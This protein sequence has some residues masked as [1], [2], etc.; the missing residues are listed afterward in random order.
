MLEADALAQREARLRA[1]S[2][3]KADDAVVSSLRVFEWNVNAAS[4]ARRHR[5]NKVLASLETDLVVLTEVPRW[6]A[7]DYLAALASAGL[8][9]GVSS[10]TEVDD[11]PSGDGRR[12]Y[13]VVVASRWP[14]SEARSVV[15]APWPERTLAATLSHPDAAVEVIAVYAPLG[16]HGN[17]KS[18]TFEAIGERLGVATGPVIVTGDFNAPRYEG[19]DDAGRPELVTFG[20]SRLPGGR[21]GKRGHRQDVAE[22]QVLDGSPHGL[23]DAFRAVHGYGAK[24]ASWTTVRSGKRWDYR[25]D[26][27]LVRGGL[28][29]VA[30]RY[31]QDLRERTDG[32]GRLSDHA[33][34]D[35]ELALSEGRGA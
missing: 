12:R 29:P 11:V 18:G 5:Q 14:L 10:F 30:A 4:S 17:A 6:A 7:G 24:A 13:G 16:R 19:L 8:P 1:L 33:A 15:G 28:E 20:Q 27:V 9:S 3:P 31:R 34:I 32:Q 25:L 23:V 22:R 2:A 21:F 26:H 35:V